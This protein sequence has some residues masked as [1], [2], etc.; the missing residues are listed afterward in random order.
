MIKSGE[1]LFN[2]GTCDDCLDTRDDS[3]DDCDCVDL[4]DE[5]VECCDADFKADWGRDDDFDK[6]DDVFC[7]D[8]GLRDDIFVL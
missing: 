2:L 3:L 6:I 4:L 5:A 1:A 8:G 7:T